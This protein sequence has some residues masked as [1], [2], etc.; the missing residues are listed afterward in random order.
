MSQEIKHR[1]TKVKGGRKW[2]DEG[3]ISNN[4]LTLTLSVPLFFPDQENSVTLRLEQPP[5][6]KEKCKC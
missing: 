1:P 4:S 2:E 6:A 5:M 3:A